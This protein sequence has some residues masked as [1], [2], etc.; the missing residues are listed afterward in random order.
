[1]VLRC[2]LGLTIPKDC[3]LLVNDKKGYWEQGICMVFDD[4]YVH[5]AVNNS[6]EQRVILLLDFGVGIP[7]DDQNLIKGKDGENSDSD[8]DDIVTLDQKDYLDFITSAY[9]YGV[10]DKEES[11]DNNNNNVQ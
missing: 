2:H 7:V 10:K 6:D 4:T 3:Y 11:S 5:S 9:G 8:E 1:M